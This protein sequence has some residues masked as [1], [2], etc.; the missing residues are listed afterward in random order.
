MSGEVTRFQPAR[1]IQRTCERSDKTETQQI[2]T[3]VVRCLHYFVTGLETKISEP[4][5]D[6]D[7]SEGGHHA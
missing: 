3:R 7:W 2:L 4:A 1:A 5:I 6:T